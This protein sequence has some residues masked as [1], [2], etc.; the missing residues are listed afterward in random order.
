M[1]A[2]MT[3]RAMDRAQVERLIF[4]S[5]AVFAIAITLLVIELRLP[6]LTEKS[7][8]GFIHALMQMLPNFFG[9]MLSFFVIGAFW[10]AH[11]RV[12]RWV[13]KT[14]ETLVWANLRLLLV[15]AFL[16]F[17][18]AVLAEHAGMRSAQLF[19]CFILA[20]AVI[21]QIRLWNYALRTPDIVNP[22]APPREIRKYFRRAWSLLGATLF[23]AAFNWFVPDYGWM[24]FALLPLSLRIAALPK[25]Q[26]FIDRFDKSLTPEKLPEQEIPTL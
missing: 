16:P 15:I 17:P 24:A 3:E 19:Y 6:E 20:I 9:F 1:S 2:H 8:H 25:V 10:A 21:N 11:H 4:F 26:L 5:D 14:D 7:T 12:F 22:E 18:T 13:L 23:A